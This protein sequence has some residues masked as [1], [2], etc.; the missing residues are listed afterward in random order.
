MWSSC[1]VFAGKSQN[2]DTRMLRRKTI[3]FVIEFLNVVKLCG[4]VFIVL[5]S[6]DNSFNSSGDV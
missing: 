2:T 1:P 3:L 6:S 4:K 5:F